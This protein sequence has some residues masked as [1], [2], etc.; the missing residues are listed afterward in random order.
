MKKKKFGIFNICSGNP[1]NLTDVAK[2]ISVR[3]KKKLKINNSK[4]FTYL[5]G[6][7]SKL[8]KLGWRI[9][10]KIDGIIDDYLINTQ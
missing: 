6:N 7:N 5:V 3:L 10:Q 2:I 1:T 9:N 8:R 4:R